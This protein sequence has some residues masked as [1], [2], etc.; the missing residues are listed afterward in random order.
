MSK[1]PW[2]KKLKKTDPD[3]PVRTPIPFGNVS[4]GEIFIPK[5]KARALME[6]LVLERAE[7][8]SR[9]LGMDRR[10][11]LASSMGFA[12]CLAVINQ[13]SGCSSDNGDG[14][15][16]VDPDEARDAAGK[17]QCG[18]A[19][20]I[21]PKA[22]TCEPSNFLDHD[23][24]VFDIQ[25]H[26]FDDGEW[27]EKN[28]AIVD[29][30]SNE[31]GS[32][33]EPEVLDCYSRN[34]YAEL[35]FVDSTTTM[36][37]ITSWPANTCEGEKTIGCGL[38]LS[39]QGMRDLRDWLNNRAMSE[40]VVN[41]IQV[42]PNDRWLL[43]KDIMTMTSEDPAWSAVSWKCYPAWKS[44][45]YL[46]NGLPSGYFLHDDL[47]QAFI[48]HGLDLCIPNFAIHKG[49][50]IPG[51]D[52]EHNQSIDIGPAA[53]MFPDANFIV[54]HSSINAGCAVTGNGLLPEAECSE[55]IP[56]DPN[57]QEPRGA[58]QLIKS[59]IDNGIGPNENVFAELGT[60]W[61]FA[62]L[63]GADTQMHLI[64]KLLKYV[65]EDNVLW[66]TDA[67][68]VGTPQGQI[69]AFLNLQITDE[70]Q[71]RYQYPAL[72]D[73]IKRKI[74]GLNAARIFRIDPEKARCR[75]DAS[76]FAAV[77]RQVDGE[78]GPNRWAAKAPLGPRSPGEF[79]RY[80]R[81]HI[82]K[83]IPG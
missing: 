61:L 76:M 16:N 69:G 43:Q 56:F 14:T 31:F 47:G 29:F 57:D 24:F 74:L 51:F 23:Y 75:A 55:L 6:K 48:Q 44:D 49:L 33:G 64:G 35:M 32:C 13:V 36:A 30:L 11:F 39:N 2:L 38:P 62:M 60:A 80:A 12:T 18:D 83:K 8:Q 5:N 71:N 67:I 65:G 34:R 7:T 26:S 22:A 40:R 9:R 81:E 77:K 73:E 4:N 66:G 37:V 58:N 68:L 17:R 25:T 79:L 15:T 28:L 50:A 21:V 70:F 53:K 19:P 59:M 72:T 63:G 42:M 10:E 1:L 54:Y 20:F 52:V 46:P 82:A 3:I 27:R 41:Q 45:S 78:L